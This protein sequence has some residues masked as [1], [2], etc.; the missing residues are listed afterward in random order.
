MA[1][2]HFTFNITCNASPS[3]TVYVDSAP[4]MPPSYLQATA[5]I[6]Y[7]LLSILTVGG[8]ALVCFIVF[9]FMGVIT[10]TNLFIANLALTDLFIGL[11][12]IPIVFISDYLLSDWPFGEFMCK[13][14]SFAQSVVVVCTVYTLVAMSVDRYIAIIHPLKPK[15]TRKQCR[16]LIALLWAFSILFSSP[17]F[18][19]MDIKHTCFH[20]DSDNIT[21]HSQT[22]CEAMILPSSLQAAYNFA[23]ITIIYIVPLCVLTIVYIRL[24]WRLHQSRAPGEAHSERDAKIKKSKQKVIK[25]CFVVVIMFGVCWLPMQLYT[26][27]LRPYLTEIIHEKYVPH[28][29]F[30]FHLMAMSNSCVNPAIYGVMSSKFRAGYLHYWHNLVTCC[31]LFNT[32]AVKRTEQTENVTKTAL[33]HVNRKRYE[34]NLITHDI[35]FDRSSDIS[36]P[37]S[38]R[39]IASIKTSSNE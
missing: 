27:I 28:V 33:F 15:L 36:A 13:F 14:T 29:Y 21:E 4:P 20:R 18:I 1:S 9:H 31:G 2:I 35:D 22:V 3:G 16:L 5:L 12:C 25:M 11:F 7:T 26:N 38:I 19:D 37:C 32:C 17:I 23:T 6:I 8:N 39:L 24:G 34:L 30:A 10:V